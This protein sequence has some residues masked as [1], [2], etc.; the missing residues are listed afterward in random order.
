MQFNL[1]KHHINSLYFP[2][3]L[4]TLLQIQSI[5]HDFTDMTVAEP[6]STA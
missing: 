6:L 4:S 3:A 1:G 2:I 5:E